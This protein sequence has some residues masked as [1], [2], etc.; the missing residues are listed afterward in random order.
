MKQPHR[1]QTKE[2]LSPRG[3][4][5]LDQGEQLMGDEE[6]RQRPQGTRAVAGR[7]PGKLPPWIQKRREQDRG[8]AIQALLHLK[9]EYG[10]TTMEEAISLARKHSLRWCG[11]CDDLTR[12]RHGVC[13]EC[14]DRH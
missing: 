7:G 12:H 2:R 3:Q 10:E 5:R 6:Y 14:L 1:C 8:A 11:D 9:F 4:D 13:F